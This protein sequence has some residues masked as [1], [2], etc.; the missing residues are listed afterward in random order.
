[1]TLV[2]MLYFIPLFMAFCKIAKYVNHEEYRLSRY[3]TKNFS[4]W[5]IVRLILL[6]VTPI[7][8]LIWTILTINE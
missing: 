5:I 4:Y 2:L 3:H 7:V 6:G 8:N 1:M